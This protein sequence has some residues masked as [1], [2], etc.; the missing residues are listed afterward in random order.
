[1]DIHLSQVDFGDYSADYLIRDLASDCR[2]FSDG[3]SSMD[4]LAVQRPYL[5]ASDDA[6]S[7]GARSDSLRIKV[8]LR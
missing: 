4:S 3:G 8:N 5:A 2:L 7:R 6:Y 1:M